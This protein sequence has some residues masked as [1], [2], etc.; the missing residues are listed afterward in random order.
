MTLSPCRTLQ[1]VIQTQ[2]CVPC[3]EYAI[4]NRCVFKCFANVSTI[5]HTYTSQWNSRSSRSG[6]EA[7]SVRHWWD[8]TI[9]ATR[10]IIKPIHVSDRLLYIWEFLYIIFNVLFTLRYAKNFI[11]VVYIFG[12]FELFLEADVSLT[13]VSQIN[14][15]T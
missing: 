6:A 8:I 10:P 5:Q 14:A 3:L 13:S 9:S 15:I 11:Y 12:R 7:A 1:N 2:K 4:P